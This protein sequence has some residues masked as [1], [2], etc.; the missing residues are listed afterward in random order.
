MQTLATVHETFC[1]LQYIVYIYKYIVNDKMF[2]ELLLVFV[3]ILRESFDHN[4]G[5]TRN[6]VP[7]LLKAHAVFNEEY[8]VLF[9]KQ[10]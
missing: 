1:Y 4:V 5:S 3:L 7:A 6:S 10:Q 9:R 2:R 8:E